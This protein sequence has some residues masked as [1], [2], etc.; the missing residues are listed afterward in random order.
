MASERYERIYD[1]VRRVP[2]GHVTSYGEIARLAGIPR[3]ARQVGYALHHLAG[4]TDIPWHRVLN[5]AGEI[6]KRAYPEDGR[7]QRTLLEAEGVEFD[8]RG[9]VA[10][11]KYWWKSRGRTPA[12]RAATRSAKRER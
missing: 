12:T 1:V 7:W 8:E 11:R 9:R 3:H 4:D 2:K 5:A 10:L 6:A